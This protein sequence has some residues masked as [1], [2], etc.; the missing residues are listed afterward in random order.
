MAL[1]EAQK[2]WHRENY[3]KN[4]VR[5]IQWKRAIRES[6]PELTK[7]RD[8]KEY[9][10]RR[11]KILVYQKKYR[12]LNRRAISD[13]SKVYVMKRKK[14]DIQFRLRATLR[15]RLWY[16]VRGKIKSG[17]SVRDLGCSVAHLKFYLEGKFT[18]GMSWK[19]YGKWHVD[20]VIPLTFF[21][22]TD[23]AQFLKA[24]HYTNLQPL[25]A[26]D[27]I[28]KKNKHTRFVARYMK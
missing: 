21:D 11:E 14:L 1:T 8:R 4:K 23:R 10:K 6:N 19:N 7:L 26:A 16:A 25:W 28:R 24:V 15:C 17:S 20:H 18:D 9:L 5:I 22:L 3:A 13:K 27:N 2:L 12:A